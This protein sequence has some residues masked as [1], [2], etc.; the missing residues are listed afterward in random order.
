MIKLIEPGFS[1]EVEKILFG[2]GIKVD[3]I[4]KNSNN[5]FDIYD[6]SLRH[7]VKFSKVEGLLT[8]I[9]VGLKSKSIPRGYPV[10]E[11]G[12][13]R[14][15]VQRESLQ[16]PKLNEFFNLFDN[17]FC[18]IAIGNDISGNPIVADLSLFPNLLIAGATGSGK[19]VVLHN[20]ILSLINNGSRVHLI[21]PKMVEFSSYEDRKEVH[22]IC[23]DIEESKALIDSLRKKMEGRF[24]ILRSFKCRN[25]H[26]Y[27]EQTD[28][29]MPPIVLVI[30]EWADLVLQ[31]KKI[32]LPL[33]KLAQK[34]RAAGISIVLATQRPST[35]VISGLIKA[36]FL[37]RISMR[38]SN[39][40]DSRI[41]LDRSGSEKLKEIGTGIFI[42]NKQNFL[43]FKSPYVSNIDKFLEENIDS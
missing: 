7:G 29:K 24:A 5:N 23:Y 3:K 43:T 14:I 4:S 38:V 41:I 36:N 13:Y 34:G 32:E 16:A 40:I 18:P 25:I 20:I 1:T 26:E 11:K 27:N 31:D 9:G 10:L 6:I 42:D 22:D 39:S 15:E 2:F 28:C 35:K 30:D 8:E 21:D 19:S 37:G 33:C 17:K 12:I